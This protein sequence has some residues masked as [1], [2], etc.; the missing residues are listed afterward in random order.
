MKYSLRL[1][2]LV[3]LLVVGILFSVHAVVLPAGGS[4]TVFVNI[5]KG[6]SACA[7]ADLLARHG[8][9]RSAFGFKIL[10]FIT[11]ESRKLKP[12]GYRLNTSMSPAKILSKIANGEVYAKW[13]TF[14]EGFTI[15]QI[16]ERLEACGLGKAAR[17]SQL[18]HRHASAF[19][20][21]FPL[22]SNSLEGYLFPDTYLI[23]IGASEESVIRAMLTAFENKVVKPMADEIAASGMSLH[24]IITLASLIEREAKIPADRPLISAVLR[25]RLRSNMPL[26]CDATVLYALGEHKSRVLYKYLK[27][28]SPYNTYLYPGLPPG[29]IANPGLASI[30][31]ALYPANV[32]YM[33]YVARP[34]GSHIFSRT[35]EEHQR[36]IKLVRKDRE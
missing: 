33:Y 21:S 7:I 32:D 23:P 12:G 4:R 18:A 29:P 22:P 1:V 13:V 25:N 6:A 11:G 34:D 10:A 35:F 20:T 30:K 16:G 5:P 14:P 8:A 26:Q 28:N 3:V 27:I 31:A 36:A 24:Q 15:R 19:Q 9:I 2:I 17:F